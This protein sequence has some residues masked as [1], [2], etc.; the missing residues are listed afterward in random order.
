MYAY[1]RERYEKKFDLEK[2]I[3]IF[4]LARKYNCEILEK[5]RKKI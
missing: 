3:T 4:S 5:K 2:N 1:K